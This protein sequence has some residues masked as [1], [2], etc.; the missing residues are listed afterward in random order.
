MAAGLVISTDLF[1]ADSLCQRAKLAGKQLEMR[2]LEAASE[3]ANPQSITMLL[4][5]L[6][7]LG[8]KVT[9]A[10]TSLKQKFP[11]ARLTA[12]GPHVQEALLQSAAAAGADE[13]LTRGQM[14]Q[15]ISR[16]LSQL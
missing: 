8:G 14:N 3:L 15:Q 11:A 10:I 5:D 12:F 4:V 13:V 7:S 16:Y 9:E 1:F 6:S 2:S